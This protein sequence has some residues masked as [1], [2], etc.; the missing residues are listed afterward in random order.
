MSQSQIAIEQRTCRPL[1]TL[2]E[3]EQ[4]FRASVREFAD[5]ELRPRVD[6]MEE[7][8]KL[9][10]T[11]IKQCFDLGLMGIETPEEYGGAGA[12]FFTAILAVEEL[13]R[14][15][16][17]VGVLVDVQNTLVNNALVRWGTEEQ[18]QKYLPQL[19]TQKVGAYALSEA[20]SGSDAFA[21]QTRAV[22]D[23]DHFVI[24]GRKL[25]I[26][27]GNEA[28]I[29]IV[30]ANANPEAGYRGI[31]AFVVEKSTA[32]FSVG[33]KENKLGI[34]ASSTVELILEDCRVSKEDVIGEIGKGYKVSIETLNEGR[35]GIGAQMIGIASGALDAALSYTTEREQ[36]GKS[37]NQFQ[38][39]QF[40]LAEMA[41]ELEAARLLVYNAARMKDA[42]QNF[43]KEAAMAKLFSSRA[44]E[45]ISS[46]AI[47]LF[48]GYGFVKDYP[49]EKFWRDSKI[50]AIYEG[51]SNMQLQTIAKLMIGK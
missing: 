31:T 5:G 2:S 37:I 21:M 26:T 22:E 42:G 17:S 49:V 19:A 11:L 14:V 51:T 50:G 36:F 7:H 38:G 32:G 23:G 24:N 41:T 43:V 47:E 28:D 3:D 35:I 34:R 15:D 48:G 33:K 10:P 29:F 27:N 44:A 12:T 16:A 4:M 1:T 46:K 39:V 8:A 40:Q 25:W 13:S 9:D 30:F 20:G 6:E 18:K 45:R